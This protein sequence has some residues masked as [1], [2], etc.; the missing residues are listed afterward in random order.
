MA[1]V[2]SAAR[3]EADDAGFLASAYELTPDPWQGTVLDGW[4]GLRPDGRWAATR[5]GLAVPRQNG[6]NGVLEIDELFK[7]VS[8]GRRI[9]HTAHE[10][11]T[12]RKAFLRLAG[13]FENERQWPELADLVKDIRRTNGQEAIIL[14]N[15]GSCEFIARSKNAGRGFTV[16]DLVCDEAQ[17]LT[18]DALAALL[19][20]ISAAPSGMPQQTFTGTPPSPTN[21]G[22]VFTR[23][24]KEALTGHKGRLAWFEWSNDPKADLDDPQTIANANPALGIRLGWE[25]IEDER[26]AMDDETFARERAG[27][28]GAGARRSVI[29]P[30]VW[31]EL[32]DGRSQPGEPLA[33]GVNVSLDGK[34]AVIAVAG[35]RPD[36]R[37]HVELVP[38][39]RRHGRDGGGCPGTSWVADRAAELDQKWKPQ[40]GFVLYPGGPAGAQILP[41]TNAG[42]EPVL[43]SGRELAAACGLF[44]GLAIEDGLRHLGQPDLATA[45]DGAQKRMLGDA[46]IWHM[47]DS[48]TEISPLYAATLAVHGVGKPSKKR[49][50]T[51]RAAFA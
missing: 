48:A 38:C 33:F 40:G 4:L 16:D 9:L 45:V 27:V 35:R 7:M 3:S 32:T 10:V 14:H 11:K 50:R 19:P 47:K 15:G 12:C 36:E 49:R 37:V 31:A 21:N 23:M 26:A 44:Y 30:D 42:V 25:T 29:D 28:W 17:E 2:P 24:R 18:E 20:T 22:E 39:C 43:I 51:G 34:S 41:M 6:K 1:L 8:L 13:F 5:R 46:W